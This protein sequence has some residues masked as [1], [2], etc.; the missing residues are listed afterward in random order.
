MRCAIFLVAHEV[1][2]RSMRLLAHFLYASHNNY[3]A[4]QSC[5]SGVIPG[6]WQVGF[7]DLPASPD[8]YPQAV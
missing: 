4:L 8:P 5:A 7:A 6:R 1:S 3:S 2:G